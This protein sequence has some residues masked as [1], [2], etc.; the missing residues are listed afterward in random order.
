[1]IYDMS[2][3]VNLKIPE[4]DFS[5]WENNKIPQ[6]PFGGFDMLD[7][8]INEGFIDVAYGVGNWVKRNKKRQRIRDIWAFYHPNGKR[9]TYEHPLQTFHGFSSHHEQIISDEQK[10]CVEREYNEKEFQKYLEK[11]K[12][13]FGPKKGIDFLVGRN[14]IY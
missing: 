2:K 10:G 5:W 6:L 3:V 9:A 8:R 12:I 7:K 14:F 1:M 11:F 4:P 13:R